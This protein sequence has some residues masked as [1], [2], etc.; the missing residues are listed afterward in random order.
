MRRGKCKS[1]GAWMTTQT[2]FVLLYKRVM[3]GRVGRKKQCEKAL[4]IL[5]RIQT[6]Q[7]GKKKIPPFLERKKEREEC[8]MKE[9]NCA[10]F[11]EVIFGAGKAFDDFGR[12]TSFWTGVIAY[13]W[14]S[15]KQVFHVY[16]VQV[17][18]TG[19]V[20]NSRSYE[21]ETTSCDEVNDFLDY[22]RELE[23]HYKKVYGE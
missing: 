22:F 16:A 14:N 19:T 20:T 9:K 17:L 5:H 11:K 12:S 15:I 1:W 13:R 21:D 7:G 23:N 6:R 2:K 4:K 8:T 10:G 18:G 3:V